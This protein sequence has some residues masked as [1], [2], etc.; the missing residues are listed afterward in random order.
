MDLIPKII[1]FFAN[2]IYTLNIQKNE[3][4]LIKFTNFA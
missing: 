2:F 3:A 1:S 4:G